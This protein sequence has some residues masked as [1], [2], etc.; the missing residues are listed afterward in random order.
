MLFARLRAGS[1]CAGVFV[2]ILLDLA[3]FPV[4][5]DECC[6]AERAYGHDR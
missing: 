2:G 4:M 6:F 3:G 1:H 5:T